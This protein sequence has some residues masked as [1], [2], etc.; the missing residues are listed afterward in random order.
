[1][2]QGIFSSG[3]MASQTISAVNYCARLNH[4]FH[5]D[6]DIVHAALPEGRSALESGPFQLRMR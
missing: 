6:S 3:L 1:M 5:F 4:R 2:M